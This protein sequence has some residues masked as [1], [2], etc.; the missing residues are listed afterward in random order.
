MP[1]LQKEFP[2]KRAGKRPLFSMETMAKILTPAD[3]LMEFPVSS[4]KSRE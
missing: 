2:D 1:V 3:D 4:L